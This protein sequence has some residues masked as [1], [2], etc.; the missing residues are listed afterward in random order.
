MRGEAGR[1]LFHQ[2]SVIFEE[3][4]LDCA[5]S[6]SF[7]AKSVKD[8]DLKPAQFWHLR[9]NVKW[10]FIVAQSV[11]KGLIQLSLL[12]CNVI[13]LSLGWFWIFGHFNQTLE[14]GSSHTNNEETRSYC[15]LQNVCVLL[16]DLW[17]DY[18][19]GTRT[20]ILPIFD[21]FRDDVRLSWHECLL[22]EYIFCPVQ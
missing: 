8:R 15:W 20:L 6:E 1:D 2:V 18:H 4:L 22:N 17:I 19:Q 21:R 7:R 9:V 5:R 3:M 13:R 14:T 11:P 12:F 16:S 10:V